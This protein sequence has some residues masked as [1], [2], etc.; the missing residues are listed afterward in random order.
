[1]SKHVEQDQQARPSR[2]GPTSLTV[3]LADRRW[4]VLWAIAFTGAGLFTLQSA[5]AIPIGEVPL[6]IVLGAVLFLMLVFD[7]RDLRDGGFG[8]ANGVTLFRGVLTALLA[9]YV[10]ATHP[11]YAAWL[12]S[13]LAAACLV[14]DGADGWI[15]R[16][17]QTMTAF[18]ERF[19]METDALLLLVLSVLI[20]QADKAG[21]WVLAIGLMRYA[22]VA[23]GWLLPA[24]RAS[25]PGSWRRKA[26]C[27]LQGIA[28][29]AC[30]APVVPPS[31]SSAILAV[32]LLC[33]TWSFAVDCR[34]LLNG[35]GTPLQREH[36]AA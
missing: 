21:V 32:C 29:A 27:V 16:R 6:A 14:L 34:W 31:M 26:V 10:G 25:L 24:L 7:Q 19:D 1:M 33:L 11:D 9:G 18:G 20:Y 35:N 13:A 30:L 36:S 22:F 5:L 2:P 4:P 3:R 17:S 12:A 15:A 8:A 23:A 28:L